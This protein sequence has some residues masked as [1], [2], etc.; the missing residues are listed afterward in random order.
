DPRHVI[1]LTTQDGGRNWTTPTKLS[2]FNPDS[3]VSAVVLSDGRIL[4][5]LNNQISGRDALEMVISADGGDFCRR[6]QFLEVG[7]SS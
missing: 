5:V 7:I 2:L 3:A 4:A 6:W 1:S